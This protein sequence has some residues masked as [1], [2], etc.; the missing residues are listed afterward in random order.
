MNL[1]HT[2]QLADALSNS[3]VIID[4]TALINASKSDE[5]L[6]L[7]S[8]CVAKGCSFMTISAVV[9]EFTRGAKDTTQLDSQLQFIN[10]LSIAVVPRVEDMA[11]TDENKTFLF[12][13]NNAATGN[14]GEKGPSYADSLLCLLAYKYRHSGVKLL[15]ANHRDIPLSMFDRDELITMSISGELRTEAMYSFSESK[16]S[17][18][19]DRLQ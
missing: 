7:L 18:V 8:S 6:E 14:R 1:L 4:S 3:T 17:K 13:Y 15:T 10:G 16:Y 11:K 12:A 5:F 9:H 2:P 19:L